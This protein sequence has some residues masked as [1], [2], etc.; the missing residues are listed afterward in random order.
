[1][2]CAFHDI[3]SA[4]F[5]IYGLTRDMMIIYFQAMKVFICMDK[6]VFMMSYCKKKKKVWNYIPI[7]LLFFSIVFYASTT[8]KAADDMVWSTYSLYEDDEDVSDVFL[9]KYEQNEVYLQINYCV[10]GMD[11]RVVGGLN[12]NP[13][14][15]YSDCSNNRVYRAYT[16]N[17]A[18][19]FEMDNTVI[20]WNY[21]YAGILATSV[22]DDLSE[23]RGFFEAD[24]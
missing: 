4:I 24:N 17:R 1:M 11:F 10:G 14:Y 5:Y 23:S 19:T 20:Q 8:S 7:A 22:S 15:G 21:T 16:S 13:A 9:R 18:Q 2:S 6:E 3:K 12:P